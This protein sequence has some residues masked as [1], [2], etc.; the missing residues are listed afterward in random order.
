MLSYC[1]LSVMMII[2][3][4]IWLLCYVLTM[5]QDSCHVMSHIFNINTAVIFGSFF[6]TLDIGNYRT[7]EDNWTLSITNALEFNTKN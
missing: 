6:K 3:I 2:L 7:E 4:S 5:I 1:K